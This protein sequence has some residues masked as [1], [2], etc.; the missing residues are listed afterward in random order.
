M[1]NENIERN[2][3]VYVD[4]VL[5]KSKTNTEHLDNLRETFDTI[6]KIQDKAQSSEIHLWNII[7]KIPLFHGVP[8]RN[9][10]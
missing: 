2:V 4:D 6:Q 9:I 8:K 1:F 3:E 10:S 5:V 7:R